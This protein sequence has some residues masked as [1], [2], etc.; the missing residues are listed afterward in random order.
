[1]AVSVSRIRLFPNFNWENVGK[2]ILHATIQGSNDMTSWN[3]LATIDQTI[4]SGWN[5][6]KSVDT[7]PYRYIRFHHNSTS[8]CNI[9]EFEI[10]GILYSSATFNLGSQQTDVVYNDGLNTNIFSSA[11]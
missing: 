6:I 9:A 2:K 4:H 11:I 5:V 7:T 3:T 1:M 10:Y 8:Q